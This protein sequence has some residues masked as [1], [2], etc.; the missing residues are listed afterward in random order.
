M[1]AARR[2]PSWNDSDGKANDC[3]QKWPTWDSPNLERFFGSGA[4]VARCEY[5]H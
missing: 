3:G 2:N 5:I 1:P 4:L